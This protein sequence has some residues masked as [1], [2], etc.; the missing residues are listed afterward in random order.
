MNSKKKPVEDSDS[1]SGLGSR[2][3]TMTAEEKSQARRQKMAKVEK[4]FY[5][6]V[7][8]AVAA[9]KV[10]LSEELLDVVYKYSELKRVAGG[11]KPLL[12]PKGEDEVLNAL[13]GEDTEQD[14]MKKPCM[15]S[16]REKISRSL[17]K[18]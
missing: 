13:R 18:L 9:K 8:V 17:V 3:S 7:D 6:L 10:Q 11:N 2:K 4:E 1:E 14:K 15:V 16:Q 12:P 5:K